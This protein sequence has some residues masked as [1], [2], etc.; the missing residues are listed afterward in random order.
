M[1]SISLRTRLSSPRWSIF[2]SAAIFIWDLASV[3]A[4]PWDRAS[5]AEMIADLAR[6]V[7]LSDFFC[8]FVRGKLP[9][10]IRTWRRLAASHYRAPL[11]CHT[12]VDKSCKKIGSLQLAGP[13][14]FQVHVAPVALD[15]QFFSTFELNVQ[16]IRKFARPVGQGR[17]DF[18]LE[19]IAVRNL[20]LA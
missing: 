13:S 16:H 5:L 4:Q 20:L 6:K 15:C 12:P 18:H 11:L 8:D 3:P 10:E 2:S 17:H 19:L 9:Q 1:T 7:K 14:L